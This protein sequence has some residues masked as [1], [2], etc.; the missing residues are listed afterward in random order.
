[1]KVA[2]LAGPYRA[3]TPHKTECNIQ[4]AAKH[5]VALWKEG[6]AVICPHKNSAQFDGEA[7]DNVWLAGYLEILKRCDFVV[8]YGDT[9][10]SGVQAEIDLARKLGMD[11]VRV[12]LQGNVVYYE[13]V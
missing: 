3:E 4:E 8:L 6:F 2:Y 12:R 11:I 9:V 13:K 10:S 1:M 5:A 7:P